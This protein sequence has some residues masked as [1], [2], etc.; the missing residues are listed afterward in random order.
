MP[1]KF[2]A[3]GSSSE[4]EDEKKKPKASKKHTKDEEGI[5]DPKTDS[6][7]DDDADDEGTGA[8]GE[9]PKTS[10]KRPAASNKVGV[11]MFFLYLQFRMAVVVAGPK[12]GEETSDCCESKSKEK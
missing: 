4:R 9:D 3:A 6:K 5:K 11:S 8:T 12:I 10:K 1:P 2:N 7:K